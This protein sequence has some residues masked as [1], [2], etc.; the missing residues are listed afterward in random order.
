MMLKPAEYKQGKDIFFIHRFEPFEAMRV[1]GELLKVLAPVLGGAAKG[2]KNA[3]N[4]TV[5][6]RQFYASVLSEALG[7]VATYVNGDN[8]EHLAHLLLRPD[9]I[10]FA[11]GGKR[12][13]IVKLSDSVIDEVFEGRPIDMVALMIQVV[14][15]NYMD[16]SMLSSL[17]DGVQDALS[18]LTLKVQGK[19]AK[20]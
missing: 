20:N 7:N 5:S 10:A 3:T 9:Y 14:K 17:P 18:N 1:L 4:E 15:V 2:S 16:F 13:S 11:K 8:F 6:D 19:P 12:D